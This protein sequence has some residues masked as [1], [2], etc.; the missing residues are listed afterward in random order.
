MGRKFRRAIVLLD[1]SYM[2]LRACICSQPAM[3]VG[4]FGEPNLIVSN[5]WLTW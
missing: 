4:V 5:N 3:P 2:S 1:R